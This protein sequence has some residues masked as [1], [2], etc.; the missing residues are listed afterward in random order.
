MYSYGCLKV[1]GESLQ[2][3]KYYVYLYREFRDGLSIK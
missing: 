1:F 3:G 2:R